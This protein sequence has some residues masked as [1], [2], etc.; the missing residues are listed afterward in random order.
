VNPRNPRTWLGLLSAFGIGFLAVRNVQHAASPG[1]LA[2]V[3]GSVPELIERGGCA[4]CHGDSERDVTTS[5]L[6]CH[7]LIEGHLATG[8]GLHGSL[9]PEV[10]RACALCH[11]E[12]HGTDF[13]LV[14]R[15]SFVIAGAPE[16]EDFYHGFIGFPMEGKHLELACTECHEHAETPVLSEGQHRF[17]G[18]QKDC[19][20]CHDDPHGVELDRTCAECHG[21]TTFDDLEPFEHL[22][23]FPLVDSHG[24]PNCVECHAP[25]GPHAI[26]VAAVRGGADPRLRS[27]A[28]CHGDPHAR[29]FLAALAVGIEPG[30]SCI[31]C[32]DAAHDGFRDPEV[33]GTLA[34]WQH[35]ASGFKLDAPHDGLECMACHDPEVSDFAER[36][37]G[38]LQTDCA[39]C[40]TDPHGGQFEGQGK[41][42]PAQGCITCHSLEAFAPH[43][44]DLQA[45]GTTD[46]PLDGAHAELDCSACHAD[47]IPP[48][49]RQFQGIASRCEDCHADAHKDAFAAYPVLGTLE[50]GTCAA[51]HGTQAFSELPRDFDHGRWTPF[52][53]AGAHAQANC[54]SCHP[55]ADESDAHGRRF[56][57]ATSPE[58]GCASCHTD[59]HAGAFDEPRVLEGREGCARC[60]TESSWRYLPL[61]FDHGTWTGFELADAHGEASCSACHAPQPTDAVGRSLAHAIGSACADCHTNPHG[62]QFELSGQT[63]CRRCHGSTASFDELAFDH[64]RDSTY[65]LDAAHVDLDCS[66]C[67]RAWGESSVVRYKPLGQSCVDC[68]GTQPGQGK[69]RR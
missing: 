14:N 4:L 61:G 38:R 33:N 12:H 9:D 35:A 44:F 2:A 23:E 22:L 51:C 68:H 48:A 11:S 47:P 1:D 30:A 53:L 56:G 39:A 40:H 52:P 36:H 58:Q 60:H 59:P 5:C 25:A 17:I 42:Q 54:E 13:A 66:A 32:H 64:D 19:A 41:V 15:R 43:L 57:F 6:E 18:L 46:L 16:P 3:H 50:Q 8:H 27:C 55:R 7:D 29:N 69:G 62:A 37:P 28:D 67:H 10:S 34:P 49:V 20:S 26:E 24:G 65:P 45:H 31:D 21:Q 63:D